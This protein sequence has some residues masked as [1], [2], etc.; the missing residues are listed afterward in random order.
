MSRGSL[1]RPAPYGSPGLRQEN[2]WVVG[3]EPTR[4]PMAAPPA[5]A[6]LAPSPDSKK[7]HAMA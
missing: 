4:R 2:I 5:N 3:A 1:E 6:N 7:R